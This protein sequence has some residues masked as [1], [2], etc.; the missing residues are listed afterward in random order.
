M[1]TTARAEAGQELLPGLPQGTGAQVLGLSS[2]A[3]PGTHMGLKSPAYLLSHTAGTS[4]ML[5][6]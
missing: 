5:I 2:A 6:F 1:G 4:C 3:F